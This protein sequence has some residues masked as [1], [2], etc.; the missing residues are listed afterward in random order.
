LTEADRA[1]LDVA[2]GPV[3]LSER[4]AAVQADDH[5]VSPLFL[6][7]VGTGGWRVCARE[8]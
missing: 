5:D 7:F 6:F 1:A 4:R 3:D 8:R 2:A